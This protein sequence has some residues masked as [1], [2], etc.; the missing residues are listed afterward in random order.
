MK[1][2][3]LEWAISE[4]RHRDQTQ[5]PIHIHGS[6]IEEDTVFSLMHNGTV[7]KDLL[8]SL[9]TDSGTD[10]S[11]IETHPPQTFGGGH[12]NEGGWESVVDSE[13]ILLHVMKKNKSA[14]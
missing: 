3:S 7:N 6:F 4:S 5:F 14:W 9:I 1:E 12:W 13:L 2:G 10:S 11:W 8:L